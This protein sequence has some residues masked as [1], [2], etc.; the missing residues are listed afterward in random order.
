MGYWKNQQVEGQRRSRGRRVS[1][2]MPS[3]DVKIMEYFADAEKFNYDVKKWSQGTLGML[4]VNVR[5][6]TGIQKIFF[7]KK[8]KKYGRATAAAQKLRPDSLANSIKLTTRKNGYMGQIDRIG[9]T[10]P[11][12][13]IWLHHGVSRGHPASKPRRKVDWF[14]SVLDARISA[15]A[16]LSAKYFAEAAINYNNMKIR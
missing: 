16:E 10:F 11:L 13:G 9:Y 7:F 8:M 14:N 5:R 4:S 15:L 6:L 2:A 3:S 1:T 12:H